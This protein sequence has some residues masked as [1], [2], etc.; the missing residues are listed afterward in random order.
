MTATQ[1]S[2]P[3]P[4]ETSVPEVYPTSIP[5]GYPASVP[6][7]YD[8]ST[9]TRSTTLTTYVTIPA[10]QST[11]SAVIVPVYPTQS[12]AGGESA[13]TSAVGTVSGNPSVTYGGQGQPTLPSSP[14]P[15]TGAGMRL[16][17]S[18]AMAIAV[19]LCGAIFLV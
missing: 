16:V 11:E 17:G 9:M 7:G 12:P 5:G 4:Y 6:G 15:Q 8:V 3:S 19:F 14:L 1:S 2:G 13:A 10:P 18:K